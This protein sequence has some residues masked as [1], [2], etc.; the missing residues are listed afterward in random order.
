M[1]SN[2][3]LSDRVRNGK[4]ERRNGHYRCR[5][6]VAIRSGRSTGCVTTTLARAFVGPVTAVP[7]ATD[8]HSATTGTRGADRVHATTKE[9]NRSNATERC[10]IATNLASANAK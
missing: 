6:V 3:G 5:T 1:P 9:A 7:N 10:A 8:A 2:F 4:R